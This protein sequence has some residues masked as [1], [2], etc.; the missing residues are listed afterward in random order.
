M[1]NGL[2]TE[3]IGPSPGS[4]FPVVTVAGNGLAMPLHDRVKTVPSNPYSN[5]MNLYFNALKYMAR[6]DYIATQA[7]REGI[8]SCIYYK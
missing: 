7:W 6:F 8:I 2:G 1:H 4:L 3:P 5:E